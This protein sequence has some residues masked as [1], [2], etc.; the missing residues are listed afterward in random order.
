MKTCCSLI[1]PVSLLMKR[2]VDEERRLVGH[3]LFLALLDG[4]LGIA[5]LVR[6]ELDGEVAGEVFDGRDVVEGLAQSLIE[7]PLETVA[8]KRDKIGDIEDFRDLG[9]RA[10][11]APTG[12]DDGGT[13]SAGHQAIP[14]SGG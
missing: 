9:E 5:E 12:A 1:S 3:V 4:V 2:H 14:P 6:T 7:E 10:A 13:C 11:L 8:L